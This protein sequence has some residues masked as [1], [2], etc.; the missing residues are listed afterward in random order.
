MSSK[1]VVLSR[2]WVHCDSFVD[3]W[4]HF[5]PGGG[6]IT[7]QALKTQML[8]GLPGRGFLQWS[9][10][11]CQSD[12]KDSIFHIPAKHFLISFSASNQFALSKRLDKQF[13]EGPNFF[14]DN[15]RLT[16]SS[17]YTVFVFTATYVQ[18]NYLS[19]FLN[20]KR[21]PFFLS[22]SSCYRYKVP[23]W[24]IKLRKITSDSQARSKTY[25]VER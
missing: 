16:Y 8:W 24:M 1:N 11:Y 7:I 20:R 6:K 21:F 12:R 13:T 18:A 23:G 22:V 2:A 9:G 14:S 15:D 17:C 10:H 4:N 5:W 3:N 19:Y 25:V